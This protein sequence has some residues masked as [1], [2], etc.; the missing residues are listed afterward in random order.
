VSASF[1]T[2]SLRNTVAYALVSGATWAIDFAVFALLYKTVP[3]FV[4]MFVARCIA[5]LFAFPAQRYLAFRL[6]GPPTL[7]EAR[8]YGI[9]WLINLVIATFL[10]EGASHV[11]GANGLVIKVAVEL[12][13]FAGNY[14]V[15]QRLVFPQRH[16]PIAP[17]SATRDR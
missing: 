3:Y 8:R 15:L 10:V 6:Q 12:I 13:V 16:R 11:S 9:L 1:T 4:A 17:S 5:A 2:T 14:F 7:R